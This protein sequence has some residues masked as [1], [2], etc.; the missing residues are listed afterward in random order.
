MAKVKGKVYVIQ[1]K[2]T[3]GVKSETIVHA[4]DEK[5]ADKVAKELFP[6]SGD[7]WKIKRYKSKPGV[8][9]KQTFD[10]KEAG[11]GQHESTESMVRSGEEETLNK[12][13]STNQQ[14][15]EDL[16]D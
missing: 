11:G 1:H 10:G 13:Y 6:R 5:A 16:P 7:R 14:E 15:D 8:I 9:L 12:T 3:L 2:S 4:P